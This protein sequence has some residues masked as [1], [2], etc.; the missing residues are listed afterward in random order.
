MENETA[1]EKL[2]RVHQKSRLP[3]SDGLYYCPVCLE[4]WPCPSRQIVDE[5][6][7]ARAVELHKATTDQDK[8]ARYI[9]EVIER[10]EADRDRWQADA[11]R[12][13]SA[14]AIFDNVDDHSYCRDDEPGGC[15]ISTLREARR[16]Y[17]EH[18]RGRHD[19]K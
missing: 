10:I 7:A 14:S 11:E 18:C 16:A 4:E 1:L 12:L 2:E 13:D 6:T 17:A 3:S 15:V 9:A 19:Q 8:I 5:I